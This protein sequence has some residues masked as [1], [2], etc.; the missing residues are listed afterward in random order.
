M[1]KACLALSMDAGDL[2]SGPR[3]CTHSEC[4]ARPAISP[5]QFLPFDALSYQELG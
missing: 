2:T 4:F 5:A 1:D 3:A